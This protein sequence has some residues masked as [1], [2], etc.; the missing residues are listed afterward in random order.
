MDPNKDSNSQSASSDQTK[1]QA[2]PVVPV[3]DIV[4]RAEAAAVKA[5]EEGMKKAA[6]DVQTSVLE[7]ISDKLSSK[8]DK[9]EI[10]PL[11]REFAQDPTGVLSAHKEL[12]IEEVK[13]VIAQDARQK[14]ADEEALRP[15]IDEFP[16]LAMNL[17]Y[18]EFEME[19]SY[20][21][22]PDLPRAEHIKK[23]AEKAAQKLGLKKLTEEEKAKR[24]RDA[25]LPTTAGDSDGDSTARDRRK[26]GQEFI[27]LRTAAALATRVKP[28]P[29][30]A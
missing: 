8:K 15:L 1:P 29:K 25:A 17:D 30:A 16:E 24:K 11:L 28:Q 10:D 18:A 20:R 23:G 7:G 14:K 9:Q 4:K 19:K 13:R 26:V 2:P 22:N 12:T 27:K 5:V 6:T 3:E 21:E